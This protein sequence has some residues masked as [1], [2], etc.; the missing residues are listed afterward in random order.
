M[1]PIPRSDFEALRKAGLIQ[2]RTKYTD[3]NFVVLNK[4]HKSRNKTYLVSE[5]EPVLAFLK[6]LKNK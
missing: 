2:Y 5:T 4:Q 1:I 6:G 3:P